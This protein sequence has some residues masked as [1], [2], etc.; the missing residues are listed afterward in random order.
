[1]GTRRVRVR[2]GTMF[3]PDRI[4]RLRSGLPKTINRQIVDELRYPQIKLSETT[5]L[6]GFTHERVSGEVRASNFLQLASKTVP[7]LTP[8]H[9]GFAL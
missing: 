9:C 8:L 6:V 3:E 1:M 7:C 2:L 4:P 5:R